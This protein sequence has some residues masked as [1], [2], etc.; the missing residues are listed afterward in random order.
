MTALRRLWLAGGLGTSL[1]LAPTSSWGQSVKACIDTHL[2]AQGDRD[3]GRL[4]EAREK[5]LVCAA[6]ACPA[7]IRVDC[8]DALA[9]VQ[10]DLPTVVFGAKD[11]AGGE[12]QGF[13]VREGAAVLWDGGDAAAVSMNPGIHRLD[14]TLPGGQRASIEAVV[15]TGD[16]NLPVIFN[17]AQ[18]PPAQAS[19]PPRVPAA[20]QVPPRRP[21]P[22]LS[23][24]FGGTAVAGLGVFAG[25]GLAGR[26]TENGFDGCRPNCAQNDYDAMKR[27]YLVA[28]IGLLVGLVSTG[29]ATYFYA[30]RPEAHARP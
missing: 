12:L 8:A 2:T 21:V 27:S 26:S 28:D 22:M 13:V 1:A 7:A 17:F 16:R 14:A 24:V 6:E 3:D 19:V 29:V 18:A 9:Q 30:T 10:R 5:F 4:R 25:F 23:W 20:D 15:R 11:A